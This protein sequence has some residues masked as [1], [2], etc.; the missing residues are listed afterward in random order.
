MQQFIHEVICPICDAEVTAKLASDGERKARFA[1]VR[2][3]KCKTRLQVWRDGDVDILG[4][5]DEVLSGAES[6]DINKDQLC[7]QCKYFSKKGIKWGKF[8]VLMVIVLVGAAIG[9]YSGG[10]WVKV[11]MIVMT[12]LAALVGAYSFHSWSDQC[13][14][15]DAVSASRNDSPNLIN[16][17]LR[18]KFWEKK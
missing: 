2:C 1:K 15:K 9:W 18:C 10:V 13:G 3:G 11:G 17:N 5:K 4:P 16:A 12:I 7:S 14:N 8:F 6:M